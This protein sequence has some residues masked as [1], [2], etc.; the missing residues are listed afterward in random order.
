MKSSIR[1][2]RFAALAAMFVFLVFFAGT[3]RASAQ[4]CTGTTLTLGNNTNCTVTFCIRA[5][6]PLATLCTTLLPG[7]S[8][9]I[10]IAPGTNIQGMGSAS[11]ITYPFVFPSPLPGLWWARNITTRPQGCCVD[12][13]YDPANCTIKALPT[14]SNPPCNP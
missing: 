11:N 14:A 4:V 2:T 6:P 5:T 3:S 9:F 13:Y 10:P 12:F 8:A 7:G 1:F